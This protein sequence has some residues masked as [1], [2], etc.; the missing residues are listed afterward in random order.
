MLLFL[1]VLTC[2]ISVPP[3]QPGTMQYIIV[4]DD[5]EVA[6]IYRYDGRVKQPTRPCK[7][8]GLHMEQGTYI[9]GQLTEAI[10]AVISSSCMLIIGIYFQ[11]PRNTETYIISV[12]RLRIRP[13]ITTPA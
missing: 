1:L 4:D 3:L 5:V 10:D 2:Q 13:D 7:H 9:D 8:H 12:V 6:P 11:N